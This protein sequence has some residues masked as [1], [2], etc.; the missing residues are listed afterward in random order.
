MLFSLT[1]AQTNSEPRRSPKPFGER[2]EAWLLEVGARAAKSCHVVGELTESPVAR[3]A[4]NSSHASTRVI[5]V[6]VS[7]SIGAADCAGTTLAQ[8]KPFHFGRINPVS[9]AQH[10]IP[11]RAVMLLP[12]LAGNPVVTGPAVIAVPG[13]R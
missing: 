7:R 1:T 13:G 12:I 8:K 5:V 11:N 2:Y 9:P 10:E 3:E 4:Q 6:E